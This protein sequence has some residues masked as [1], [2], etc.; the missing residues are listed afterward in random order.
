MAALDHGSHQLASASVAAGSRGPSPAAKSS[1]PGLWGS[2]SKHTQRLLSAL[3]LSGVLITMYDVVSRRPSLTARW[4]DFLAISVAVVWIWA[5]YDDFKRGTHIRIAQRLRRETETHP[6]EWYRAFLRIAVTPWATAFGYIIPASMFFVGAA[7]I[8][9]IQVR[10]AAVGALF[11]T[12]NMAL[13]LVFRD[14]RDAFVVLAI[15]QVLILATDPA[16]VPGIFSALGA[17]A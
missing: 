8:A 6:I 16:G 10:P 5:G 14:V 9:G 1:R 4:P 11:L 17:A 7:Y 15:A 13:F 2:L 3:V 12:A